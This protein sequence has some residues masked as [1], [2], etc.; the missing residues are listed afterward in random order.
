[1]V[2]DKKKEKDKRSCDFCGA[3]MNDEEVM[4]HGGNKFCPKCMAEHIRNDH[5][6]IDVASAWTFKRGN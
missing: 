5:Y 3:P 4:A 2:K 6:S 1:M